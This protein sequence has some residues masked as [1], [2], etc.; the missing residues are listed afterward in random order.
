MP[1]HNF[2]LNQIYNSSHSSKMLYSFKITC[3]K[4][5]WFFILYFDFIRFNPTKNRIY[6]NSDKF[7]MV[8][9]ANSNQFQIQS[10]SIDKIR[11]DDLTSYSIWRSRYVYAWISCSSCIPNSTC[12]IIRWP[13][14][15]IS[16]KMQ[17]KK[18]EPKLL[19]IM[20]TRMEITQHKCTRGMDFKT[21]AT[22]YKIILCRN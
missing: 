22:F 4:V 21:R 16:H 11:I 14:H 5:K 15:H 3:F 19:Q 1:T 12:S 17:V 10:G 20:S 2:S 18:W 8:I 6:C 13:I 9:M 7:S